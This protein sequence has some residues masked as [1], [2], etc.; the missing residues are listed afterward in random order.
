MILHYPHYFLYNNYTTKQLKIL[1]FYKYM[2]F[3]EVFFRR[4]FKAQILKFR[5]INLFC[6]LFTNDEEYFEGYISK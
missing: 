5:A 3:K 6:S 2:H 1:F 4:K